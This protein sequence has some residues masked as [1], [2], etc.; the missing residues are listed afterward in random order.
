MSDVA[1]RG[2]WLPANRLRSR[3]SSRELGLAIAVALAVR[4]A[5]MATIDYGTLGG[6]ALGYQQLADNLREHCTYSYSEAPPLQPTA[7]R[8]P[9]YATVVA[10]VQAVTGRTLVGVQLLQTLLSVLTMLLLALVAAR[11]VPAARRWVLFGLALNPF[12]G[13]YC[14]AL[15]TETLATFGVAAV[16]AALLLLRG[17]RRFFAAGALMGLTALTRDISVL[18]PAFVIGFLVLRAL[19]HRRAWRRTAVA[20]ALLVCGAVLVVSPWTVRNA[21]QFGRFIPIARGGLGSNLWIGTWERNPDWINA[22]VPNYPDEA[23]DNEDDK[24]FVL[25]AN[26]F[27]SDEANSRTLAMALRRWRAAPLATLWGCVQRARFTWLGT[28]SELVRYRWAPLATPGAL[29]WKVLKSSQ[30]GLNAVMVLGAL[31][32]LLGRWRSRRTRGLRF[33]LAIPVVWTALSYLLMH[34][35]ESRYSQPVVPVLIVGAA[36]VAHHLW[37]TLLRRRAPGV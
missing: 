4:V 33:W 18:L 1:G 28:R 14:V 21:V 10:V 11:W 22:G 5:G 32:L 25:A 2:L 24:Q 35:T 26:G 37:I 7:L 8:A 16:L 17:K 23:F 19:R 15:L 6:D 12:D 36:V 3:F 13:P 20:A 31:A 27:Y 29:P 34:S 9:L 30:W